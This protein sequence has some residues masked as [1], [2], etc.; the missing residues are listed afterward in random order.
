MGENSM[1]LGWPRWDGAVVGADTDVCGWH[2]GTIV[3][4][5][6][7][8]CFWYLPFVMPLDPKLVEE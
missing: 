7:A 8:I 1:H 2:E 5:K 4:L 6:S 3:P